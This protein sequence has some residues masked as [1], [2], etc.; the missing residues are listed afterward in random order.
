MHAVNG[1]LQIDLKRSHPSL[2]MNGHPGLVRFP[3]D[4]LGS[5]SNLDNAQQ[6]GYFSTFNRM[7][8]QQALTNIY[9]QDSSA[10]YQSVQ[11][12][13]D[14]DSLATSKSSYSPDAIEIASVINYLQ[15]DL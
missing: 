12:E 10:V 1:L 2:I 9:P 5:I 6:L 8:H 7:Q 3:Q 15:F 4:C 11:G 14:V 13:S